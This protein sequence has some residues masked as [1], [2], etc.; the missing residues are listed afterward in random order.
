M[1]PQLHQCAER[2]CIGIGVGSLIAS[3]RRPILHRPLRRQSQRITAPSDSASAAASAITES[4]AI[5][6]VAK[7]RCDVA[8]ICKLDSADGL[9]SRRMLSLCQFLIAET[10]RSIPTHASTMFN[11]KLIASHAA[12]CAT[13]FGTGSVSG[14]QIS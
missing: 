6:R 11:A 12:P 7:F 8:R 2:F 1:R 10:I 5:V 14:T 13:W 4:F 9:P 3:L